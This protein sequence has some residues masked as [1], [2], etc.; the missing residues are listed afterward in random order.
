MQGRA[1]DEVGCVHGSTEVRV[2]LGPVVSF[3]NGARRLW[4]RDD[5]ESGRLRG[6]KVFFFAGECSWTDNE[7]HFRRGWC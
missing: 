5:E 6:D 4:E 1:I 2:W 3:V 7:V